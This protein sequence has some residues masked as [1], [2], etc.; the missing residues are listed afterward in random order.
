MHF[1]LTEASNS[2]NLDIGTAMGLP[3]RS[4]SVQDE[5]L[6]G[7]IPDSQ[8]RT[9]VRSLNE[10]KFNHE[11][12]IEMGKGTEGTITFISHWRSWSWEICSHKYPLS[13]TSST[14]VFS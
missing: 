3:P 1:L 14:F 5:V 7:R 13:S 12:Y 2:N 6:L 8:F 10:A 9:L 4:D 11:A